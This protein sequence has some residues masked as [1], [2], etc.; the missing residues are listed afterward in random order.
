MMRKWYVWYAIN[1]T[2]F[3]RWIINYY[4]LQ[5]QY[6]ISNF[7]FA[8]QIGRSTYYVFVSRELVNVVNET[9]CSHVWRRR[10]QNRALMCTM[11]AQAWNCFSQ[12]YLFLNIKLSQRS[13]RMRGIDQLWTGYFVELKFATNDMSLRASQIH[14]G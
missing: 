4:H 12:R 3:N 5:H 7:I 8:P 1:F 9:I 11:H 2:R 6:V 13:R 14:K 10:L